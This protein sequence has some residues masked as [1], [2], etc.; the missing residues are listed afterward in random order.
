MDEKSV[1][2]NTYLNII[3]ANILISSGDVSV[4][5]TSSAYPKLYSNDTSVNPLQRPISPSQDDVLGSI[6]IVGAILGPWPFGIIADRF[7]K[8]KILLLLALPHIISFLILGLAKNIYL[9]YFARF[10]AGFGLGAGYYLVPLY[11]AEIAKSSHRGGMVGVTNVFWCLGDFL[12]LVIGTYTNFSNYNFCLMCFPMVFVVLFIWLGIESP[13]YLMSRKKEETARKSLMLLR[14]N[15]HEEVTKELK[16]IEYF[17]RLHQDGKFFDMIKDEI[18]RKNILISMFLLL[19]LTCSGFWGLTFHLEL[20]FESCSFSLSPDTSAVI[21]GGVLLISSLFT[22]VLLDKFG[23]KPLLITSFCGMHVSLIILGIYFSISR[24]EV[25]ASTPLFCLALY[26][27]SFNVGACIIPW[28]LISE[29]FPNKFKNAAASY[30]TTLFWLV[31]CLV[32]FNFN[33]LHGTIGMNG[34]FYFH[35]VWCLIGAVFGYFFVPETKGKDFSDI[36]QMFN[37]GIEENRTFEI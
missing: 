1:A 37:E 34:I 4:T 23:R 12:S 21:V 11:V 22:P 28:I 2:W 35:G 14:S 27:A 31:N 15:N 29:L 10:V 7:G 20:I 9:F 30:C 25:L 5:W 16:S 32:T 6:L 24:I 3:I 36:Q 17:L 13:Y 18:L 8:K 26:L 19:C 33:K